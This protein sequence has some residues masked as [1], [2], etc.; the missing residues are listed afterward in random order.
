MKK[1]SLIIIGFIVF[2]CQEIEKVEKPKNLIPEE[3]MVKILTE[4]SLVNAAKSYNLRQLENMGLE[5]T[6]YLYNKFKIDSVQ[7]AKSNLYYTSNIEQYQQIFDQVKENLEQLK[8]KNDS[9][10]T[11]ERAKEDSVRNVKRKRL[12]GGDSLFLRR[13]GLR[14]N[15]R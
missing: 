13:P 7:F 9:I 4:L 10:L 3:K 11:I 8:N 14:Q 6:Q 5:P 1:L 2:S 15:S 12:P